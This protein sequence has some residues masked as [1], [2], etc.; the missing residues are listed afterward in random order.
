MVRKDEAILK[1]VEE[2]VVTRA[3]IQKA[4][5]EWVEQIAKTDVVVVGAGPSGLTAALYL[6]RAGL[7][8]VV[9]EKRLSFGGG[10]GPGPLY[11]HKVVVQEP[12]DKILREAGCRLEP[13]EDGVYVTDVAEMIAKLGSEAIDA[14]AKIILGINVTDVLWRAG[15]PARVNGVVVEWTSIGMAGLH[16]DPLMVKAEAVVDCTGRNAEV[17]SVAA[18][19]IPDLGISVKGQES[20]WLTRGEEMVVRNAGEVAPGLYVAGLAVAAV[21][22]TPRMGPIYGGMLLGGAKVA[23]LIAQK[24]KGKSPQIPVTV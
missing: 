19:K 6:A 20:L 23:R 22:Q 21:Y 4:A 17:V 1:E 10:I 9:F 13:V 5:Q 15:P 14:G 18:K 16:V 3:T 12:A 8:T 7:K 2:E 11:F 24:L